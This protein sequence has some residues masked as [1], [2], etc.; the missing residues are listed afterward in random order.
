MGNNTCDGTPIF[1]NKLVK[2]FGHLSRQICQICE[3]E[4]ELVG[5]KNEFDC[6]CKE[7]TD[8]RQL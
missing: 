3:D 8:P 6:N 7:R 5:L 1:F 4:D 2:E